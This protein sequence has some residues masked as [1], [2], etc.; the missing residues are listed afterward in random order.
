MDR[1]QFAGRLATAAVG[2]AL[3][4]RG[5]FVHTAPPLRATLDGARLNAHLKALSVFGANPAGG[6]S[7]VAYSDFDKAGRAYVMG[8][9]RDAGLDVTV[10][11]A[12]N[13]LGRRAGRR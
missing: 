3:T 9:M 10:D 7:R 12:G 11:F 8:L 5:P 4:G 2:A 1:R 13:I 6:V